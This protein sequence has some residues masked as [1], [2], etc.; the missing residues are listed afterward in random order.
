MLRYRR[1][2]TNLNLL[3]LNVCAVDL[4][5][6]ITNFLVLAGDTTA[7]CKA[8]GFF[9]FFLSL[10]RELWAIAMFMA[11]FSIVVMGVRTSRLRKRFFIVTGWFLPLLVAALFVLTG[12]FGPNMGWCWISLDDPIVRLA[13]FAFIGVLYICFLIGYFL[14][15]RKARLLAI[16]G[17]TKH[18]ETMKTARLYIFIFFITRPFQNYYISA[19]YTIIQTLFLG[20]ISILNSFAFIINNYETMT[21]MIK[22]NTRSSENADIDSRRRSSAASYRSQRVSISNNKASLPDEKPNLTEKLLTNEVST[23]ENVQQ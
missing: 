20:L 8:Q 3:A 13:Y 5:F 6:S 23:G 10:S 4:F 15:S 12:N 14:I 16:N 21:N 19:I 18:F 17:D 22:S 1:L 11:C 7:G 2:R 9:F